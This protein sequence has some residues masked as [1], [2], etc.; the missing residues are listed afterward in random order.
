MAANTTVTS[1]VIMKVTKV[2]DKGWVSYDHGKGTKRKLDVILADEKDFIKCVSYNESCSGQLKEGNSL[3]LKNFVI[4][5][6]VINLNYQSKIF[7][8]VHLF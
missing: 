6:E 7:R 2:S 1:P 8:Y 5:D 3:T 4:R